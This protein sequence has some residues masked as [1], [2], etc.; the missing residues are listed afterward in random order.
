MV[1]TGVK[2]PAQRAGNT[3]LKIANPSVRVRY[4]NGKSKL[5]RGTV[6]SLHVC[7]VFKE[8]GIRFNLSRKA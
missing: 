8:I 4:L 5:I 7:S 6:I 3:R 2:L 1:A